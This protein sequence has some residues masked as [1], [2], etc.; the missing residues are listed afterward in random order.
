MLHYANHV[1]VKL[2]GNVFIDASD[3]GTLD[4]LLS[5]RLLVALLPLPGVQGGG[6]QGA[7]IGEG[8]RPRLGQGTVVNG[9]KV[10]AGLLFRLAT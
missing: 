2:S 10:H 5:G 6:L 4:E 8:Q 1:T 3:L 9:I 7:A